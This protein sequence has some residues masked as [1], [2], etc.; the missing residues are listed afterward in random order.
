MEEMI[1][2]TQEQQP[3]SKVMIALTK[4]KGGKKVLAESMADYATGYQVEGIYIEQNGLARLFAVND[5]AHAPYGIDS[6]DMEVEDGGQ[7]TASIGGENGHQLS[8]LLIA[9]YQMNEDAA[10]QQAK[11]YGWLPGGAELEL[12]RDNQEEYNALAEAAGGAPLSGKCWT[13]MRSSNTHPWFYDADQKGFGNWLGGNNTLAVR[14]C[15]S[16][17]EWMNI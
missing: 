15:K 10:A 2:E 11:A 14:P 6:E 5:V 7:L 17:A 9:L 4:K 12:L 13:A 3:R 8:E 1:Q 16:A